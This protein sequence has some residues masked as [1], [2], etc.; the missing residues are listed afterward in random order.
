M[1]LT[2]EPVVPLGNADRFFIGGEWVKPSSDAKI[3]VI[4][5]GTEE[6]FFRVAEA[7]E[8]DMS[9][10]VAAAR[11]AFDEGPWPRM[12]HAQRAEYLRA[13][14]PGCGSGPEMSGR[15]GLVN[16]AC[17]HAVA[18]ALTRRRRREL[19]LL[20]RTGRHLPF[21]EP[22]TALEESSD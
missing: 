15:S 8:E 12:T 16:P 3:E 7:Q 9:R 21:E 17:V 4:D 22:A 5:S 19:R 1:T 13:I 11:E 6:F 2:D 10:A 14:G 20:R 18:K